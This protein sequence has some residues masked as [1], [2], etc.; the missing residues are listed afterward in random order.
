MNAAVAPEVL[1]RRQHPPQADLPL[2]TADVQRWVWESRYGAMLIEVVHGQIF[3][4]GQ[5][6]VPHVQEPPAR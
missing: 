3:V 5:A 2:A 4:N 1:L 6:V